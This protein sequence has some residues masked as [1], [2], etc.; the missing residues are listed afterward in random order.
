MTKFSLTV[1]FF[2]VVTILLLT[3]AVNCCI[4]D[5]A[6]TTALFPRDCYTV[7]SVLLTVVY[8][9]ISAL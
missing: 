6:L 1:I 7:N 5:G 3:T 9:I 8:S 4:I 2:S